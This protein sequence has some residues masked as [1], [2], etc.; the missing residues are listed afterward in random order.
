MIFIKKKNNFTLGDIEEA[1]R[2][3]TWWASAVI[4]PFAR[5]ISLFLANYTEISPNAVTFISFVMRILSA[6]LFF[7]G[8]YKYIVV[9]AFLFEF[10]YVLDCVDGCIAR[11]KEKISTTGAFFDHVTDILGVT[12]NMLAL[13]WGQKMLLTPVTFFIITMYLFIH[14]LT[15]V[16]NC[17]FLTEKFRIGKEK[18]ETVLEDNILHKDKGGIFFRISKI[19]VNY[20]NIFARRH[21]KAFFSPPD[22]EALVCFIFPILGNVRL[23]FIVGSYFLI[24][25]FV[26]KMLSYL[27][28]IKVKSV[29]EGEFE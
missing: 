8:E 25:L 13:A 23:G 10:A 9:A 15:F 17:I 1:L 2:L 4:L 20:R 21:F 26:Y 29:T 24:L 12:I 14:Y 5:R 6:L 7:T 22:F 28:V 18:S 16:A 19:I 11:L 3:K 27:Y